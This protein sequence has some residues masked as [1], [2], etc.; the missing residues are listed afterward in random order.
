MGSLHRCARLIW[1]VMTGSYVWWSVTA[2]TLGFDS[3]RCSFL[4]AGFQQLQQM[5]CFEMEMLSVQIGFR[6]F[7]ICRHFQRVFICGACCRF[8]FTPFSQ[9]ETFGTL[10]KWF[11]FAVDFSEWDFQH[12]WIHTSF[13]RELTI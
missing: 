2:T 11:F 4:L 13:W 3:W 1:S 10:V 7:Q 12:I 5:P 9:L 8:W 6:F